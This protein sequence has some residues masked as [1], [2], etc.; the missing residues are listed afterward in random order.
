M[1]ARFTP[2]L[3]RHGPLVMNVVKALLGAVFFWLTVAFL[4]LDGQ[5]VFAGCGTPEAQLLLISGVVGLAV[6]DYFYL[7]A[8]HR[9]GV[10]QA[11]LLHGT[12]PLWLLLAN[13]AGAG[14][15]L[16]THQVIGILLV[17]GGVLDV[18]RR[19]TG[20]SAGLR[21]HLRSGIVCGV[22]AAVAQA[23]GIQIAKNPT[24]ACESAMM[25]ST[26]RLS[27]ALGA[28]LAFSVVAGHGRRILAFFRDRTSRVRVIEPVFLGSY[29][30]IVTMT[31][32]INA[33]PEA[34]AG[35]LVSLTPVFALPVSRLLFKEPIHWQ[36]LI[37][38]CIAAAGVG[39]IS[40]G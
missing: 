2:L 17:V 5:D 10:R 4:A 12:A 15:P 22:L 6:G 31:I 21:S 20:A 26:I 13:L 14:S 36:T 9:V 25:V 19:R 28:L 7:A 8:V 29:L 1:F 37:G 38:T 32:T 39:L 33:A 40:W 3:A 35:A 27:G 23:A 34:V 16:A 18:T 11:T 30:G 24:V